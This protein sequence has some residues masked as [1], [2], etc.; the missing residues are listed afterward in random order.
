MVAGNRDQEATVRC[1]LDA[2]GIDPVMAHIVRL[3]ADGLWFNRVF[4]L[5][6]IPPEGRTEIAERLVAL[7]T[8]SRAAAAA[9]D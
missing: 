5:S 1:A 9:A 7:A 8:R 3:A 6:P 2:D 4:G